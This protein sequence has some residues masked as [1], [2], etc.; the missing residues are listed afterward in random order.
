MRLGDEDAGGEGMIDNII[1]LDN[2]S[3]VV[4]ECVAGY[5]TV[6]DNRSEMDWERAWNGMRPK[7]SENQRTVL[8]IR[9]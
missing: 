3:I 9:F 8:R 6:S 4:A 2:D 7:R 1:F 5:Q